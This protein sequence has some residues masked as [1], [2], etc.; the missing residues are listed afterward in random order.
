M[1]VDPRSTVWVF[2]HRDTAH[3]L[4]CADRVRGNSAAI[5]RSPVR[6]Q[7]TSG[8]DTDGRPI[9]H[10]RLAAVPADHCDELLYR[11]SV[12]KH[13]RTGT[14]QVTDRL[15]LLGSYTQAASVLEERVWV[16]RGVGEIRIER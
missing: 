11:Y 14:T 4:R 12:P 2:V 3:D 7:A 6:E 16:T 5:G 8:L 1:A 13:I 15:L 9:N 10:T